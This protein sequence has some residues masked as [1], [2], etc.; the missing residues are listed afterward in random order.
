[1]PAAEDFL[2]RPALAQRQRDRLAAL[3]A[4]VLP[5][6]TFYARKLVVERHA[7]QPFALLE[8]NSDEDRETVKR[9]MRK[10]KLTWRCWFD[11]GGRQGPIAQR[12]HVHQW[13]T[14]FVLDAR[15]V[16][17]YKEL[18]DDPLDRAVDALLAEAGK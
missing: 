15:G 7:G 13:P 2:D 16:I 14:I 1:M 6:N 10:E 5:R 11:G 12:W 8:V 9:T 17:R 18:R 4:E 3:L